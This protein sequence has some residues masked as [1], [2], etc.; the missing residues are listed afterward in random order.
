MI[1][2]QS[3]GGKTSVAPEGNVGTQEAEQLAK[4][5]EDAIAQ[6]DEVAVDLSACQALSSSAI[7]AMIACHNALRAKGSRLRVHGTGEEILR[8]LR[9]MQLDRHFDMA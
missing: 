3:A 5:M 2:S 6:G 7:G 1:R 8:L 4:A 9:I